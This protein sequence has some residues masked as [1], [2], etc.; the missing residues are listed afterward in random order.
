M[1]N[2]VQFARSATQSPRAMGRVVRRLSQLTEEYFAHPSRRDGRGRKSRLLR[3]VERALRQLIHATA[4]QHRE[5][6]D[7]D[8]RREARALVRT[9]CHG[10]VPFEAL[11]N[12]ASAL[13]GRVNKAGRVRNARQPV[14]GCDPLREEL[15]QA[16]FVERLHTVERLATTGRR[17]G[18]CAK[19][20]GYGLH[21]RLRERESDFYLMGRGDDPVAM[22]EVDLE[23]GKVTEFRGKGGGRLKLPRCVLIALLRRLALN[24]DDVD[25]CLQQGAVSIFATGSGDVHNPD[26]ERG[27]LK[28]WRGARRLVVWE[29]RKRRRRNRRRS[30]FEWSSFEWDGDDWVASYAS[31]RWSLDAL[32]TRHPSIAKLAHE[33]VKLGQG[34]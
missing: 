21:D 30:S 19:N 31:G 18:N 25:A 28:V 32:M 24:G 22:F 17:F 15:P 13:R 11:M 5:D 2:I 23:T 1:N 27:K 20:N 26:W 12:R 8:V 14:K 16:F 7:T 4:W 9:A 6:L 10:Q 3:K 34:R 33:A 29:R